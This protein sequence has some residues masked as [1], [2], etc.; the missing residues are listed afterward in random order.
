[1][2]GTWRDTLFVWG[3]P[4][5]EDSRG[6]DS[7]INWTGKWVGCEESPDA[8]SAPT[9]NDLGFRA[10][11]MAF[12]VSTKKTPQKKGDFGITT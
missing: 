12:D 6:Q 4:A 8:R 7:E 9:P 2:T 5:I 3:G 11:K 10:S 1:M